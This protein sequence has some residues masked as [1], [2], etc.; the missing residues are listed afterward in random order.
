MAGLGAL[1]KLLEAMK[2]QKY[3]PNEEIRE[4]GKQI[5][6]IPNESYFRKVPEPI[7]GKRN[8]Q[9]T[10][11]VEF[12]PHQAGTA[13]PWESINDPQHTPAEITAIKMRDLIDQSRNRAQPEDLNFWENLDPDQYSYIVD[14]SKQPRNVDRTYPA[15]WEHMSGP[16]SESVTGPLINIT[17]FL[18]PI[19]RVRKA[20]HQSDAIKRN[21][22]LMGMLPPG[23]LQVEDLNMTPLQFHEG[24]NVEDTIGGLWLGGA[25]RGLRRLPGLE[26]SGVITPY[27]VEDLY[28]LNIED[29]LSKYQEYAKIHG[30]RM[31]HGAGLGQGAIRRLN[32]IESILQ[33]EFN[34]VPEDVK[35][36]L[37]YRK[38]GLAQACSC[39]N[40]SPNH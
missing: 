37:G 21:P 40:P 39:G 8:I 2:T 33:G 11:Q 18:T 7:K 31:G 9:D 30:L 10:Y 5:L 19:N 26:K 24:D 15:I 13:V 17:D 22:D 16:A 12:S 28:H 36:G 6:S 23:S 34:Q 38:G 29:P 25:A 27:N 35:T 3:V 20:M 14:V 32:L 4:I 1:T